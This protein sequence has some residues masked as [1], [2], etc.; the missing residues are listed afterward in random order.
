MSP[1]KKVIIGEGEKI[2]NLQWAGPFRSH[3]SD[4]VSDFGNVDR[5]VEIIIAFDE[6]QPSLLAGFVRK[7]TH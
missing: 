6:G 4:Q 7:P 3:K 1:A 5:G 2:G